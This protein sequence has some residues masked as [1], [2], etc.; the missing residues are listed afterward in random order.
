MARAVMKSGRPLLR[1]HIGNAMSQVRRERS[2][3]QGMGWQ[4]WQACL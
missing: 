3:W 4:L 2:C 1:N